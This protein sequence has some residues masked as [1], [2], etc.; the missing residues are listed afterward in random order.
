M[1][2]NHKSVLQA[3][4]LVS[5]SG[6]LYG[7]LG[8]LGT[9]VLQE[10]VDISNML[11]W[12]FFIAG[13]WMLPFVIRKCSTE[14][15]FNIDKHNLI[16]LLSL[17]AIGYA[18]SSGFYFIASEHTGT[19]L[20]MVIFFSY[21]ILI[22]LYSWLTQRN[23]FN[24]KTFLILI[25]MMVG[26]ILLGKKD[27]SNNSFN[28]IGIAGGTAAA[29]SYALYIIGSKKFSS[30]NADSN[31][32]SMIVSFACAIIYL[33]LS[34]VKGTY[35]FPPMNSWITLLALGI[36]AT[37][38]PIQL[39]LE[40]LKRISSMRASIISVLE[41]IVTVLVGVMLLEETIS[42]LQMLGVIII[43]GSAIIVQFQKEL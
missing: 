7:F 42:Y 22:A 26:L 23:S 28:F 35:S 5:L 40:G 37:A 2:N 21:P 32:V 19:G 25:S 18:G 33:M 12:R 6:I 27:A 41:P 15:L 8:F 10:N 31:V 16:F 4:L 29:L 17:G 39:M 24:M 30:K 11:F 14:K 13:C 38:I 9:K 1:Q 43:L 34:L 36:F 3:G 20:A